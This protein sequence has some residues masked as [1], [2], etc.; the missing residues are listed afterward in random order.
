MGSFV[1]TDNFLGKTDVI[2]MY[3][4]G[5]NKETMQL[6]MHFISFMTNMYAAKWP[7]E[8]LVAGFDAVFGPLSGSE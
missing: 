6:I 5:C 7:F 2:N 8:V 1:L 4:C 3:L